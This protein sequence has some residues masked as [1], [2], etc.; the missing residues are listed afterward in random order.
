MS[1]VA[2]FVVGLAAGLWLGVRW[3][4]ESARLDLLIERGVPNYLMS[5]PADAFRDS[6]VRCLQPCSPDCGVVEGV[7]AAGAGPCRC[8]VSG[9]GRPPPSV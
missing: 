7:R 6:D 1:V 8:G 4:R 5:L 9:T 3:G 2:A